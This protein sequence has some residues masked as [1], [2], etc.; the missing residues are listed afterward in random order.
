VDI[1]KYN[2]E[3][4]DREVKAGNPWTRPVESQVTEAARRGDW[5][6]LLTPVKPVPRDWFGALKGQKVLCLAS[7]GGQQGPI[8][9]AAGAHVVVLDNSPAQLA[10]DRVVAARD[11]LDIQLELGRMDDLSRFPDST[12]DLIIHPVSNLFVPNIRPVWR[13]AFRTLCHR[14]SLLSGFANPVNYL[15]DPE[16][17]DRGTFVVRHALPYSDLTSLSREALDEYLKKGE[18][19]EFGHSLDD[20]IGGQLEAGFAITGF[21]EDRWPGHA[22]DKYLPMFLATRAVKP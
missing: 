8:L 20:Q 21:Y 3:A 14:G 17:V 18:P 13:E 19:L 16:E 1:T 9:A 2:R 5:Q 12:F 4:W 11:G 7:G 15:F 22:L 6:I 10:Q